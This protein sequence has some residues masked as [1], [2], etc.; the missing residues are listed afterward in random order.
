MTAHNIGDKIAT[1][2]GTYT[3]SAVLRDDGASDTSRTLYIGR[4]DP[5]DANPDGW[6]DV[7]AEDNASCWP[8]GS[9]DD[10]D[11]NAGAFAWL[12]GSNASDMDS[13]ELPDQ[14]RAGVAL[15]RS[16]LDDIRATDAGLADWISDRCDDADEWAGAFHVAYQA[17]LVP[18]GVGF[19]Q[20][21]TKGAIMLGESDD[22]ED[23]R[24]VVAKA[25]DATFREDGG[26]YDRIFDECAAAHPEQEPDGFSEP[27]IACK[28]F[29]ESARRDLCFDAGDLKR[30]LVRKVRY[31]RD[32]A[33]PEFVETL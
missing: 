19:S 4:H 21:Y 7:L 23:I 11:Q 10:A 9:E 17:W 3:I 31:T 8:L 1:T 12:G 28:E 27:E 6:F 14:V 16:L 25:A 22:L 32:G 33:A 26:E 13:P 2:A 30:V 18:Q 20:G 29:V 15:L 5:D 24:E